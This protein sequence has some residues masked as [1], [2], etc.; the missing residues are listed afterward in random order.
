MMT[1]AKGIREATAS[2]QLDGTC[3]RS[4]EVGV[5]FVTESPS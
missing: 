3:G 4:K 2:S 5:N 1:E